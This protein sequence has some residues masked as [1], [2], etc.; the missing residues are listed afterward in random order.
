MNR[1]LKDFM[2]SHNYTSRSFCR[3]PK[4]LNEGE[5]PNFNK[6]MRYKPNSI[7]ILAAPG[8]YTYRFTDS[9]YI[10]IFYNMTLW[11]KLRKRIFIDWGDGTRDCRTTHEYEGDEGP[12][13]IEI[14]Q[15]PD[16]LQDALSLD[17]E[18]KSHFDQEHTIGALHICGFNNWYEEDDDM[19]APLYGLFGGCKNLRYINPNLFELCGS[20]TRFDDVFSGCTSLTEIPEG[21]FKKCP[22]AVFDNTFAGCTNL[23][24][25]PDD[26]FSYVYNP[27]QVKNNVFDGTQIDLNTLRIG[28]ETFKYYDDGLT[29]HNYD[30][31]STQSQPNDYPD[32]DSDDDFEQDY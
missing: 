28:R 6:P 27:E 8:T 30:S 4:F 25:V 12:R 21:L 24:T 20:R 3:K 9:K 1:N 16:F 17:D 23:T 13:V 18:T 11:P 19:I 32:A 31:T 15:G 14:T 22:K 2:Q 26:L 7:Y 5:I 29:F 10:D